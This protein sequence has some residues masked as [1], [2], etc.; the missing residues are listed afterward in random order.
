MATTDASILG[1]SRIYRPQSGNG[2]STAMVFGSGSEL[3]L[4]GGALNA[5]SGRITFPPNLA[6]G[7]IPLNLTNAPI[8]TTATASGV[9]PMTT[10]TQPSRR[11]PDIT[12]GFLVVRWTSAA[13]NQNPLYFE[14]IR[15]PD[16]LSTAGGLRV[17][18]N[19]EAASANAQKDMTVHGR[20]GTATAAVD[21]VVTLTTTPGEQVATMA[22]GSIAS[23]GG[24]ITL[25]VQPTSAHASGNMDLYGAGLSYAKR[26]S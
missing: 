14:P 6:R 10:A 26:T 21:A 1:Q 15:V 16:D 17:H 19:G 13:G 2:P 12:S 7:Y 4:K 8:K 11:S 18:L 25:S 23:G 24:L 22:S 20:M 3:E 9:V 5:A